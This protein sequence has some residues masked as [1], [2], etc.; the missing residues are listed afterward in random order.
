LITFIGIRNRLK[1]H[2][3][4]LASIDEIKSKGEP[5]TSSVSN[6]EDK[7]FGLTEEEWLQVFLLEGGPKLVARNKHFLGRKLAAQIDSGTF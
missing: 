3:Y 6:A 4:V 5:K 1:N 7:I 2:P